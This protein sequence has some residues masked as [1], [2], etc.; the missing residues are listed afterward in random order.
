MR[1]LGSEPFFFPLIKCLLPQPSRIAVDPA[2]DTDR[3]QDTL[4]ASADQAT[5]DHLQKNTE[6]AAEK[7]KEC[8]I[9]GR[10]KESAGE[11]HSCVNASEKNS[12]EDMKN[13]TDRATKKLDESFDELSEL[14]VSSLFE[15]F[16]SFYNSYTEYL[17]GLTPDKIVCIFNIIMGGMTLSSFISIISIMLSEKII[18]RIKFLE[19]YPKILALLNLRILI[20]KTIAKFYLFIHFLIIIITILSNTYMLFL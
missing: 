20:N 2:I 9:R 12:T 4:K 13:E 17:D 19:R 7:A 15:F 8:A 11:H 14:K 18:N 10:Y 1:E 6:E 5:Q 16:N 3:K